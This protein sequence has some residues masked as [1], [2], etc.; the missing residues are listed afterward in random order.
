[1]ATMSI[2]PMA[3]YTIDLSAP[4]SDVGV[5][6]ASG[7]PDTLTFDINAT[8]HDY[9]ITQGAPATAVTINIIFETNVVP[10]SVTLDGISIEGI[11]DLQGDANVNLLL[12]DE[13]TISGRIHVADDGTDVATLTIDSATTP[14]SV[15]QSADRLLV[16]NTG[17]FK[18]PNAAAIGGGDGESGGIITING[19]YVAAIGWNDAGKSYGAGIGGGGSC[20]GKG[21][22]GGTIVVSGVRTDLI[23]SAGGISASGIGYGA[24]L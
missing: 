3:D 19:G 14:V 20:S 4:V 13:N 2:A 7:T 1:M 6:F 21:G 17:T 24:G 10:A 18:D 23:A 11:I 15:L 12:K 16:T 22:D 5:T 9:T 8:G